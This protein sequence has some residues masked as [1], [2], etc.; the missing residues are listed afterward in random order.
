MYITDQKTLAEVK[1]EFNKKFSYLKLEFFAKPHDPGEPSPKR[2]LLDDHLTIGQV[3][4]IHN[5]GDFKINNDMTVR[6]FERL[7]HEKY[8]LNVQVF[9]KSANVWLQTTKTDN[10]TLAEQN[11]KGGASMQHY[12]EMHEED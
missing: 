10:W 8:G 9:R 2:D 11:R 4:T 1:R 7:V 12:A 5:E 3:R 6:D